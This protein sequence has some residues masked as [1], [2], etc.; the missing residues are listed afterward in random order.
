MHTEQCSFHYL[1]WADPCG[2]LMEIEDK[3][4]WAPHKLAGWARTSSSMCN[5]RNESIIKLTAILCG[6]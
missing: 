2:A 6:A 3:T 4:G 5:F 1:I